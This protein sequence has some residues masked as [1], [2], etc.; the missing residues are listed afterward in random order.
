[1]FDEEKKAVKELE[2]IVK[3]K[4]NNLLKTEA[5][6]AID[7]LV[8]VD[9]ALAQAAIDDAIAGGGDKKEI[10]KALKEMDKAQKELDYMK[11]GTPDPKNDK[12]IDHYKKAWDHAQKTIKKE[13]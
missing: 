7:K 12:A 9:Q 3:E 5:Q 2:R 8:A 11:K 10:D 6:E 13:A 4:K 1:M